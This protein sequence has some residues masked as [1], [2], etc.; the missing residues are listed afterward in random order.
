M[1][2][3]IEA[4]N[5]FFK[6]RPEMLVKLELDTVSPQGLTVPSSAILD[7]GVSKRVFV[8]SI[9][10]YFTPREVKLGMNSGDSVQVLQGLNEGEQVATAGTF[11]IDSESRLQGTPSPVNANGKQ[12][13][14]AG[15]LALGPTYVETH[16]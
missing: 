11:L 6:L 3:K 9:Q 12:G 2:I 15:Q 4:D 1:K 13:G 10:G 5:P 7:S 8:E 16:P 14:R